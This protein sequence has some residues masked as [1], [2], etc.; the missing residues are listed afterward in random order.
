MSLCRVPFEILRLIAANL[1]PDDLFHLALSNSHFQHII[2]DKV[3]CRKAL[4]NVQFSLDYKEGDDTG[5]YAKALRTLVKRRNALRM[6]RPFHILEVSNEAVHFTYTNGAVCYTTKQ[7][8]PIHQHR[9]RILRLQ[10]S[11]VQEINIDVLQ[12]IKTSDISDFEENRPYQLKPLYYADN[13]V[14]CLYEQRKSPS[15]GRWLIIYSLEKKKVLNSHPLRSTANIFVRNNSDF[16]YYGTKSEPFDG[17]RRWVLYGFSFEVSE[18]LPRS[19]ILWDLAGS[20]IGSTICFEIF[21]DYL[22]G[23]SSQELAEL[24]DTE[25]STSGPPLNSF[26]YA[27]QFR[28]GD[29][30]TI[31]ILPRSASWRRGA[32]DGPIDDRWNQLQ[33]GQDEKSG[34]VSIFETRKEWLCS[35]S[36]RTCY[37]KQ[38]FYPSGSHSTGSQTDDR[39]YEGS[40][41]LTHCE[42][43]LE[44]TIHRGDNGFSSSTFDLRNS[45][46]RSYSPSCQAFVDIVSS[47]TA[48]SPTAKRLRLRVRRQLYPVSE[49]D[50]LSSSPNGLDAAANDLEEEGVRLWPA[51]QGDEQPDGPLSH[52]IDGLLNPQAYFDEIDWSMDERV[53]VYSPKV[54]TQL[55]E[56]RSIVLIS[57]DPALH[58]QGLCRWDKDSTPPCLL[59]SHLGKVDK[60]SYAPQCGSENG[61]DS[62]MMNRESAAYKLPRVRGLDLSHRHQSFNPKGGASPPLYRSVTARDSH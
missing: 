41:G 30:S 59:D 19:V 18:W 22:Y 57:F 39:C 40:D 37:G 24:E 26:Y 48:S 52:Y 62:T 25:W 42:A 3:I 9:L 2:H 51:D 13:I 8:S 27:F 44:D 61:R 58:F 60:I 5:D 46:V 14:S 56:P 7:T 49:S 47:S 35:W 1:D 36:R 11:P 4:E 15:C 50:R 45:P 12:L 32:T 34:Q 43:S 17:Q 21:G 16:L 38:L 10:G 29:H 23:V 20:D 6:A 55:D 31:Q 28:L 53:L 33:L 54:L